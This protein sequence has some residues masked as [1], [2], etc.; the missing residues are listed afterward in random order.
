MKNL[1]LTAIVAFTFIAGVNAQGRFSMKDRVKELKDSVALSNNQAV[2]IDSI[3]TGAG[4]KIKNIDASGQERR[5]ATK[6]IMD[7]VNTQ[8]E[9]ILTP[10]Q[11]VKYEQIM[12]E[13]RTRTQNR[14]PDSNR[15]PNN[16]NQ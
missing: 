13:K 16:G 5:V 1:I 4:E 15:P 14:P 11:K 3:F 6:K 8:V 7:D 9:N 10:E 12:A 2:I